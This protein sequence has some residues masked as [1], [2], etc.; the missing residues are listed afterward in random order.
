MN[1]AI[2]ILK[3]ELYRLEKLKEESEKRNTALEVDSYPEAMKPSTTEVMRKV[4]IV[5]TISSLEKA[6]LILES[7]IT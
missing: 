4:D 6:I 1:Y 3:N 2:Q 5:K 7:T